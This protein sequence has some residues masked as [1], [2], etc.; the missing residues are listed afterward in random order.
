M[1]PTIKL[2]VMAMSTCNWSHVV[3]AQGSSSNVSLIILE[4]LVQAIEEEDNRLTVSPVIMATTG[5]VPEYDIRVD[6]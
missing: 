4:V 5:N 6:I 3:S 2:V 1:I